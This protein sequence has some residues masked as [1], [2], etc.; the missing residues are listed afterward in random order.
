MIKHPLH[1]KIGKR[2]SQS[3]RNKVLMDPACGLGHRLPLFC[4]DEKSRETEF[5]NVDILILKDTN[6]KVIM[7]IE[8]ADI[9]P[10]QVCGKILTSAISQFYMYGSEKCPLNDSI[11]F[12]QVLDSSKL[13]EGTR[14]IEQ[15]KNLENEIRKFLSQISN[16][17]IEYHIFPMS[18]KNF[19]EPMKK[20]IDNINKSIMTGMPVEKAS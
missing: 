16:R 14:K 19:E 6:V 9:K 4:S 5:C 15:F 10:T 11:L 2:I 8:E 1:M 13:K 12:I 18:L 20:I 7:E 3:F 17:Q